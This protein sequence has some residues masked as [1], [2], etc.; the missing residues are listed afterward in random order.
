[1]R[2]E[3]WLPTSTVTTAWRLPDVLTRDTTLPTSAAEVWY[4]GAASPPL[5]HRY[6]KNRTTRTIAANQMR[7]PRVSCLINGRFRSDKAR[8]AHQCRSDGDGR[9]PH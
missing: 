7:R 3:T 4:S 2:P 6:R 8:N 9:V 5:V 1:M